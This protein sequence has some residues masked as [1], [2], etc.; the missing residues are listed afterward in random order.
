VPDGCSQSCEEL[1]RVLDAGHRVE[2]RCGFRVINF[3][4]AVDLLDIENGVS[5]RNGISR[6]ISSP[7]FSSVSLR[8]ML[9]A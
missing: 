2:C 6:S 7:V 4:Q 1:L 3:R 8:V 5:L 9:S